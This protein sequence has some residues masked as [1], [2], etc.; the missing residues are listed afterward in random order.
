MALSQSF[1]NR[2]IITILATASVTAIANGA[3]ATSLASYSVP[4]WTGKSTDLGNFGAGYN[5][6]FSADLTNGALSGNASGSASIQLFGKTITAAEL[7]A[8][9]SINDSSSE[10]GSL[11]V[12]ATGATI[13]NPSWSDG[14]TYSTPDFCKS[15]FDVS[16]SFTIVVVPV[17][18]FASAEGCL[19]ITA[20]ATP[21]Y[22]TTTHAG[23]LNLTATPEV[24]IG[25][26]VGA[27]VGSRMFSAGVE[28]NVT[29]LN[30]SMPITVAPTYNFTSQAFSSTT[31]G[32]ITLEML[33]GTFDMYAKVDL[34]FWDKKY[35]RTLFEWEGI[36]KTWSLWA[37]G[38]PSATNL[39]TT[40]SG[41]KIAGS[42]TYA[43][44]ANTAQSGSTHKWYRN[45]TDSDT[46]RTQL[47]SSTTYADRV[48]SDADADQFYQ[49]CVI[50]K[51]SGG[52]TG[53]EACS[54]WTAVGK[55]AILYPSTSYGSLSGSHVALAYEKVASGK[56]FNMASM[57]SSTLSSYP[58][59]NNTSSYKLYATTDKPTTFTF[60][61]NADCSSSTGT[62]S[63]S[64]TV[65]AA[66]SNVQT[67]TSDLGTGWDNVVSSF[68]AVYL[69][70]SITATDPVASISGNKATAEYTFS[71]S[72]NAL[73]TEESGSTYV[74]YRASNSSGSGSAVIS[75]ATAS[76]Y[77][78][79][80]ADDQKYLKFCVTPS[81]GTSMGSMVC[82]SWY[83]VGH[84]FQAYSATGYSGTFQT[85]IA[86]E[87][88]AREAC[89]N[90]SD[91]SFNDLMSSF[92]WSN[93]SVASS[94]VWLYQDA[95]CSGSVAT[96]TV[97][98]NGSDN[99]SNIITSMGSSWNDT[100][101]SFKVSWNSTIYVGTPTISIY[102][103]KA[104]ESH[105]YGDALSESGT[106]YTWYRAT[107]SSGANT[108]VIDNFN[109]STYEL[110]GGDK[111]AYL[112]V[113]VLGS[114]A[115]M[116][117]DETMCS[118]W[119]YVGP[120][121][122]L[123]A[124]E[125]GGAVDLNLA[126]TKSASG[127]CFNLKD[128]SFEDVTSYLRCNTHTSSATAY[129]YQGADCTGTATTFAA[130]YTGALSGTWNDNVSSVKVV[131]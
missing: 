101:S 70:E 53:D 103:N 25:L 77:S 44:T 63:V 14:F 6:S 108:S 74:W 3:N 52:Y 5:A 56:C 118:S 97:A 40:I 116:V 102:G 11:L 123:W 61:Q 62:D 28:V 41:Q 30:F 91:Y 48:L 60:Y 86:W 89:F 80:P 104:T 107:D 29:L 76:Q 67:T 117:D 59:D 65:T 57:Y 75:G 46:G 51:N 125:Y 33:S 32:E 38:E 129:V 9:A 16:T 92:K 110:T 78:L 130:G 131:Y 87:K 120:L 99:M 54:D 2:S 37:T 109:Q 82:S 95:N 64:K 106:K 31:T 83:S 34:G 124:D 98:A 112:K 39:A 8:N 69:D 10:A 115:L 55:L 121:L 128:Y 23:I 114:N 81:N 113:C 84:T 111:W 12:K 119:T 93:N 49:Y 73:S 4:G 15:F 50:P 126:Y 66:S 20:T 72:E 122:R 68:K 43:D 100:I 7:Q 13:Y 85:A 45:S 90:L 21:Q 26:T 19:G 79:V 47:S 22:N 96:R 127:T 71:V 17:T 35:S 88:S 18:M 1:I 105:A 42:Y 24:D 27:G 58:F 36:S 94:T